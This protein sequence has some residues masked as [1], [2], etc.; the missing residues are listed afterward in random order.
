ML[1]SWLFFAGLCAATALG[2]A[3]TL[4][5]GG[6]SGP[7]GEG[8]GVECDDQPCGTPCG[9]CDE[10]PCELVCDGQGECRGD[11]AITCTIC[12]DYEKNLP[13]HNGDCPEVGL[14]CEY[15]DGLHT[16]LT[17]CRER[18]TCTERHLVVDAEVRKVRPRASVAGRGAR[19]RTGRCVL[20]EEVTLLPAV[21]LVPACLRASARTA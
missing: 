11:W 5:D 17:D 18:V 3:D 4:D 10:P 16:G 13:T 15:N 19:H 12:P 8:G 1:R 7:G 14:V 9:T 21:H 20:V 2:C 6:G